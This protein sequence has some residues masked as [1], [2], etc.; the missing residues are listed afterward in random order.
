MND[1]FD[2]PSPF[3]FSGGNTL[4]TIIVQN[5]VSIGATASSTSPTNAPLLLN[6][7][8]NNVNAL[9]I[10][11]LTKT[12]STGTSTT[13]TQTFAFN[14]N[15]QTSGN[16]ANVLINV[17]AGE[18]DTS[19]NVHSLS[20]QFYATVPIKYNQTTATVSSGNNTAVGSGITCALTSAITGASPTLTVTLTLT[21]TFSTASVASQPL[22]TAQASLSGVGLA[23]GLQ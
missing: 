6:G 23:S 4:G 15:N 13:A 12:A 3:Q 18:Q 10:N 22:L 11:N 14:I 1:T 16:F 9:P 5:D 21:Y 7:I 19:F 17:S 20:Q 8:A 2:T